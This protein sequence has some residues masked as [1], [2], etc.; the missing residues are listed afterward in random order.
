ML[1]EGE[2]NSMRVVL[3]LSALFSKDSWREKREYKEGLESGE[4]F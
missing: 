3:P 2:N 1:Q 4:A